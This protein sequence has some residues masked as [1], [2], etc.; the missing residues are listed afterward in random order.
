MDG[1]GDIAV[2]AMKSARAAAAAGCRH[3]NALLGYRAGRY[4]VGLGRWGE[5]FDYMAAGARAGKD[6]R[7]GWQ[8]R[9]GRRG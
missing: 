6:Y 2:A 8:L 9:P 3:F 5:G 7:S 4:R 1:T